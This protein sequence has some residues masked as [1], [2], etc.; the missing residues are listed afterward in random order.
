[1]MKRVV[2][3]FFAVFSMAVAAV[4]PAF[5]EEPIL[6]SNNFSLKART[7]KL[8]AEK[9]VVFDP[10]EEWT[11]CHHPSLAFF[12]G[13]FYAVF[14]NS[15][16]GEDEC[17]QRILLTTSDDFVE[18]STPEVLLAPGEGEY[19]QMKILTPGG[20]TVVEDKLVLYY[21][22]NDN[23]GESNRRLKATL[24]AVTTEDGRTWSEPQNLSIRVFPCQRPLTLSNG[25]MILTGNT[26]V[27]YTD[28]PS[29]VG[30]WHRGRMGILRY[31]DGAETFD[32]VRPSLC[33]GS[34]F[35]HNDHKVYCLLRSTGKTYD[36][37]L[38]QMQSND[39][40]ISWTSPVKSRFTD[41]NTKSFFGNLPDGRYFYVGTPDHTKPGTRYPLVLSVSTDGFHFDR[42][43]ILSDD[44]YTQLYEGRWKGGDYGYPFALV[45]DGYVYVIVS[46]HKERIEVLRIEISA[47]Q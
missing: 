5:G 7:P 22:E 29:G 21:T 12:K 8:D 27:Y 42:N 16:K 33:E 37:Y 23:D 25:R 24:F 28:D 39:G 26:L 45:H 17:G 14:S 34:L 32:Q 35:E 36:G 31:Q 6:F 10:V 4:C 1:M 20:L 9:I 15:P 46:R 19:G 18:W 40:G 38:W 41:N 47:L 3:L 13:R 44:H 30:V 11:Y 43:W 2:I